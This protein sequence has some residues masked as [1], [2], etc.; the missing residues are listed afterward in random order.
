MQPQYQQSAQQRPFNWISATGGYG[1]DVCIA[2]AA[3]L[4][5]QLPFWNCFRGEVNFRSWPSTVSGIH[6]KFNL[7]YVAQKPR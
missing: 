7:K 1:Q 6:Q 4:E 3:G 2:S 5:V